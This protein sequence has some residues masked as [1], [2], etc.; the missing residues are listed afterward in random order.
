MPNVGAVSAPRFCLSTTLPPSAA[1]EIKLFLGTAL[2]YAWGP[3]SATA[4]LYAV[5]LFGGREELDD[6]FIKDEPWDF[7]YASQIK[8]QASEKLALALESYGV[9]ERL[10]NSGTKSEERELFGDFDRFLLGPVFNYS[11]G[12]DNDRHNGKQKKGMRMRGADANGRNGNGDKNGDD[13]KNGDN[14][15]PSYTM[16]AGVLF[17]LN[18]NTADIV[19]KWNLGVEF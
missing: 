9:V 18:D 1:K 7:Q 17:G 13:D 10:G 15:R 6:R 2:Q 8:Y 16:G 19:L 4:N 12:G 3:W 5:K 11:W 14:D